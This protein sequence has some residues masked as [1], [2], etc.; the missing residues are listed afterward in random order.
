MTS[1]A[2]ALY[3]READ[4]VVAFVDGV[5]ACFTDGRNPGVAVHAPAHWSDSGQGLSGGT[6]AA[7]QRS[8]VS[9]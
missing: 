1:N 2:G 8:K 6:A 4:R 5:A 7:G 3:L 9:R